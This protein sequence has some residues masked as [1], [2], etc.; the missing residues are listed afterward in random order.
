MRKRRYLVPVPDTTTQAYPQVA[1]SLSPRSFI[2]GLPADAG[3]G[4]KTIA[5]AL[6]SIQL[7]LG[8]PTH[9]HGLYVIGIGFFETVPIEK[10]TDP[11]YKVRGWTGSERMFRFT[12]SLRQSFDRWPTLPAG[13]SIHL[14]G[15]VFGHSEILA[16]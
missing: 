12:S 16:E 10:D 5:A 9:V 11:M 8:P 14:D 15:Y 4:P 1:E 3:W 13:W 2:V 6:R 7:S